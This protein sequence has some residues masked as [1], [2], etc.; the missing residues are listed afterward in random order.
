MSQTTFEQR[1]LIKQWVTEAR[2][3]AEEDTYLGKR[4]VPRYAP[5]AEPIE[6]RIQGQIHNARGRDI[7]HQGVGLTCKVNVPR[8]TIVEIRPCG[9]EFWIPVRVQHCTGTVAGFKIGA[10][11][12]FD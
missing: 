6:I 5:W 7:C 4:I 1:A 10:K 9:A 8:G 11:F 3:N 12:A 2:E